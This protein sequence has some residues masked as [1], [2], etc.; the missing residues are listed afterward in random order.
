MPAEGSPRGALAFLCWKNLAR[1]WTSSQSGSQASC[2]QCS[3][4]CGPLGRSPVPWTQRGSGGQ[5]E[6]A[7][8][9]SRRGPT[10]AIQ[11]HTL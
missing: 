9:G 4:D 3:C 5:T 2:S 1:V 6:A 11:A 7:H 8:A 10:D